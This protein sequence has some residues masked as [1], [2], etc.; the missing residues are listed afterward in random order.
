[1]ASSEKS[2]VFD[3]CFMPAL[4]HL[5]VLRSGAHLS[6]SFERVWLEQ[7]WNQHDI[8]YQRLLKHH[9]HLVNE[10]LELPQ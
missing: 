6:C 4:L 7:F 2:K 1:M 5:L 10:T 3:Y 9:L 8:C